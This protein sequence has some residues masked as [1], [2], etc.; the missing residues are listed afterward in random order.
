MLTVRLAH[1]CFCLILVFDLSRF[2]LKSPRRHNTIVSQDRLERLSHK[3][4]SSDRLFD[5]QNGE[6]MVA[7]TSHIV[8]GNSV[9]SFGR[10]TRHE[11]PFKFSL[12]VRTTFLLNGDKTFPMV[13]CGKEHQVLEDSARRL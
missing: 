1:N 4:V 10:A 9:G 7:S 13:S 11:A 2:H 8:S 12:F 6:L 5:Y 3:I